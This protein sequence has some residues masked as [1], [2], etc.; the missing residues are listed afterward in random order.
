MC[1]GDSDGAAVAA[2]DD[3]EHHRSLDGGDA[4][5]LRRDQL[6]IILLD[7]GGINDQLCAIDILRL[8][9]HENGDAV[10][11]DAVERFALVGVGAGEL[12]ALAVQDLRQRAH[13]RTADADKVDAFYIVQ[14]MVFI[15][16]FYPLP[17][18]I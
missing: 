4:L 9:S 11:A 7:G 16:S 15:H 13:T 18:F 12:K 6:G 14:K 5:L 1:S 2:G 10:R 3:A 8:M 17:L